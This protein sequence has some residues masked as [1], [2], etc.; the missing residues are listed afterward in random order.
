MKKL[1]RRIGFLLPLMLLFLLT[2]QAGASLKAVGPT[3]ALTTLPTW[4]QDNSNLALQ[5]C[6][7]QNGMC[8]LPGGLDKLGNVVVP[9]FAD[10]T[11]TPYTLITT[12]PPV[13]DANFPDET[14][15]YSAAALLP[16]EGGE[17][18]NLAFVLEAAFLSGVVPDGGITFLRTDLQ[19]MQ[20]L[21]PN[22]TYR[23]THPYGTFTFTTDAIGDTTGGGGVAIRLEDGPAVPVQWLPPGMKAATNT[24]IGPFLIPASGI[25]PTAIVNGE[26]HTYIGDGT[27]VAVT[28]SPN[29][30]NFFRVERLD[31][32][33][34][35]V[36]GALWETPL[37]ALNGRIFT[38]PIPSELSFTATYARNETSGQI[39]IF[40]TAQPGAVLT[41][42]GTGILPTPLSPAIPEVGKYFLHIPLGSST[43]PTDLVLTNSLDLQS[44]PP[45]PVTLVDEISVFKALYN[46]SSRELMVEAQSRDK[47]V[48]PVLS[49]T[50]F[51]GSTLNAAGKVVLTLPTDAIPPASVQVVSSYGGFATA[52]VSVV[53]PPPPPV[54]NDDTAVTAKNASV[55]INVLVNDVSQGGIDSSS[56]TVVDQ[57]TS[58]ATAAAGINGA[59]TYTPISTFTGTE[60]FTY[61]VRDIYGQTSNTAIV[62]VTVHEPPVAGNDAASAAIDTT[63]N[64]DVISNDSATA[65][66][67]NSTTVNI[68][69]PATCGT[70][71]VLA[72]GTIN[73]TAPATVP[74]GDGTCTFSY[75]VSDTF[76]PP[77]VSNVADVTVTIT[78]PPSPAAADDAAT[79]EV[80]T[81][82]VI[83][84]IA[85]DASAV[86]TIN[87]ATVA[88][89]APTGGTA[90]ANLNGTVTYNPPS[91][92]GIYTFTYTVKDNALTPLTS[93][94]ATVTVTVTPSTAPPA[95]GLTIFSNLPSPQ[96]SGTAVTFDA[97]A[98]GGSGNYQYQYW[99][100]NTAGI[101]TLVKP[102]SATSTWSWDTTGLTTGAY[103]IVVQARNSGSTVSFDQERA[104]NFSLNAPSGPGVAVSLSP[105]VPSPQTVGVPIFLSASVSG[106][107][108]TYEYQFWLRNTAGVYS[109]V[110]PYGLNSSWKWDT[111][112]A[113]P[114]GYVVAVQ[115]RVVGS[116]AAFDVEAKYNYLINA[117]PT[118]A[119]GVTISTSLASPQTVGAQVFVTGSASGGSGNYEYRFWL[120]DTLG[121]YTMVQPISAGSIWKWDT[122]GLTPGTYT[123]SVQARSVGSVNVS[124]V[125]STTNFAVQ[126]P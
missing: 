71:G 111:S 104:M 7:D 100:K 124:D 36:P 32:G 3:D 97:A 41:L 107:S 118:P 94:S 46:P 38:G 64:I 106:G 11:L 73:F 15:Y 8:L 93:N 77:A 60:T 53:I 91:A 40:A 112:G 25:F 96:L 125:E 63:V 120:K 110:Q 84:V 101:F 49:V 74:A 30:N 52:P 72:N 34:V 90:T 98:S 113:L 105:N 17:V 26:T 50:G 31:A 92:T 44:T 14:F 85:N 5:L 62:T 1:R 9:N 88:V 29:G 83:N 47:V 35:P 39:D 27:P 82:V 51:A 126:N 4:Y 65:S 43:L 10:P 66:S 24:G 99:L 86:S 57:P 123:I 59:I 81:P 78:P 95:S 109:L 115:A 19:K 70:T 12:T 6:V 22:S 80:G 114:G 56:V 48:P 103:R 121:A 58:G 21:V 108:G 67:I 122:T 89:T 42:S 45:H 33:G 61:T 117:V 28:G 68:V 55:S 116:A 75:V 102:Y 13:N 18:A 23:V 87:P 79:T 69:S 119:T 76:S 16:I 54:A 20:N 2:G 37:F